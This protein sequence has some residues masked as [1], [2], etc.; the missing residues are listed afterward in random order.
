MTAIKH[1]EMFDTAFSTEFVLR[2]QKACTY[3]FCNLKSVSR[4]KKIHMK[5]F[6]KVKNLNIL[7]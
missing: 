5:S 6:N 3:R 4:Q 2:A 7:L 1:T